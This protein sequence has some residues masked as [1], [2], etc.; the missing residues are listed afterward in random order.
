[1]LVSTDATSQFH[2]PTLNMQQMPKLH[3]LKYFCLKQN[4]LAKNKSQ[5]CQPQLS[6]TKMLFKQLS[7]PFSSLKQKRVFLLKIFTSLD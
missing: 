6:A 5:S 4:S 2:P 3:S 7:K 1:M